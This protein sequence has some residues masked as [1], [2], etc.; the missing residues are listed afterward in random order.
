MY[1]LIAFNEVARNFSAH[2]G[3]SLSPYFDR[4]RSNE[5]GKLH[6]IA[7]KF[8]RHFCRNY[9]Y[10]RTEPLEEFV[11]RIYSPAAWGFLAKLMK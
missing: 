6:F 5:T 9:G 7:H 3:L 1:R 10:Q 8:V 4:I 11:C 2:F